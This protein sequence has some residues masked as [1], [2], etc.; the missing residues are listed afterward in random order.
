MFVNTAQMPHQ[1]SALLSTG[2]PK[3]EIITIIVNIK[4]LQKFQHNCALVSKSKNA[5]GT[6]VDPRPLLECIESCTATL[7]K[8]L[9]Q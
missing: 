2:Q 9:S 6:C 7:L 3:T 5:I 8:L 4:C 1:Q